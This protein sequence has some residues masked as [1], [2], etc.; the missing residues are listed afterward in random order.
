MMSRKNTGEVDE[1]DEEEV[2]STGK[3]ERDEE[4][5][6]ENIYRS[7]LPLTAS[8]IYVTLIYS[9]CYYIAQCS[10]HRSSTRP[11]AFPAT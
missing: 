1:D 5:D 8:P 2:N 9:S 11:S 6:E 3:R 10:L 4:G 7:K